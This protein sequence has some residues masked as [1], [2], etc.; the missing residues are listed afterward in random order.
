MSELIIIAGPQAA[1]KS[2]AIARLNEQY[3]S[4]SPLFGRRQKP[5]IFPLQESRQIVVHAHML[6]GAIFMTPEHEQ[7]VVAWDFKR[8]D[9]L[10]ERKKDRIVYLDECNVFTI[11]HAMAHGIDAVK[12]HWSDYVQ[13][14]QRLNAKVI[15]LNVPPDLSWERRRRRYE[16]RL[17]YFPKK[18]HGRIMASYKN[19]LA[20]VHPLLKDVYSRLPIPKRFIDARQPNKVVLEEVSQSLAEL[21][22]AFR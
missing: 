21:S 18:E 19:Y 5:L 7:E 13:R 14:L 15:F 17:V 9:T 3:Q 11:A 22:T 1:G 12:I 10:A 8:M 2:T 20:Q 16:Q 6:L 4:I